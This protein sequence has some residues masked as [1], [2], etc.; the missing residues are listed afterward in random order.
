MRETTVSDP[1][2]LLCAPHVSSPLTT[3]GSSSLTAANGLLHP[4][5]HRWMRMLTHLARNQS[6]RA[7][8]ARAHG[9]GVIVALLAAS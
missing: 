1:L 6:E 9:V 8:L 7:G 2:E 4:N 5:T 3:Q